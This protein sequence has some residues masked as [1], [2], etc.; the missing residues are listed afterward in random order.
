MLYTIPQYDLDQGIRLESNGYHVRSCHVDHRSCTLIDAQYLNRQREGGYPLP[1]GTS[2][3]LG[4]EF[5]GTIEE[6]GPNP[7]RWAIGDEVLG[8]STGVSMLYFAVDTEHQ[9]HIL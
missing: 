7:G 4:V 3:I 9:R 2:D 8:L 6:L 1:P 5:S